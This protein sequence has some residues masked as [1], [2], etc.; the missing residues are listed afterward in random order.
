[1]LAHNKRMKDFL[2]NHGI[3]ATPKYLNKGSLRG[4]WRLW[5][6]IKWDL[7]LA[8]KLNS[9]GFVDFDGTPLERFSGNGGMFSVFVRGHYEFLD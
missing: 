6:Q 4:C 9:L 8:N 5:G 3:K 1:M 7:D 2:S